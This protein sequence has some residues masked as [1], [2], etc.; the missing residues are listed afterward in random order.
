MQIK[1]REG[2]MSG[3][4]RINVCKDGQTDTYEKERSMNGGEG[5]FPA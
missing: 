3:S 4:V 1:R 5:M 2:R